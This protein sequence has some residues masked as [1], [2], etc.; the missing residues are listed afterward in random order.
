MPRYLRVAALYAVGVLLSV[1]LPFVFGS[2]TLFVA[3]VVLLVLGGVIL[4]ALA[5]YEGMTR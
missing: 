2:W 3:L 4:L 5:I 1:G